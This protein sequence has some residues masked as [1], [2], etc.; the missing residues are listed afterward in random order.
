LPDTYT[1]GICDEDNVVPDNNSIVFQNPSGDSE[2]AYDEH[3]YVLIRILK[4]LAELYKKNNTINLDKTFLEILDTQKSYT[5]GETISYLKG[6]FNQA[7]SVL[8]TAGTTNDWISKTLESSNSESEIL[9]LKLAN[10]FLNEGINVT[11]IAS[12]NLKYKTYK[13][14]KSKH[15]R[16]I[17]VET[18]DEMYATLEEEAKNNYDVVID[19]SLSDYYRIDFNFKMEDMASEIVQLIKNNGVTYEAIL[20]VLT[21]PNCKN[22]QFSSG[23]N[24]GSNL[25]VKLTPTREYLSHLRSWYPNSLLIGFNSVCNSSEE[26]M[27]QDAKQICNK[28]Q[29]DYVITEILNNNNLYL[30]N[31][32][33]YTCHSS[34]DVFTKIKSLISK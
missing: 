20:N 17:T 21:N 5:S 9:G 15:F 29:L 2:D 12:E 23:V 32:N 10:Q 14:N 19:T 22:N 25:A 34:E 33:D 7:Q 31:N 18:T 6:L 24:Y 4:E 1:C 26:S 16:K 27:V 8:I 3:Y 13:L 11:L 30:V 28:Y